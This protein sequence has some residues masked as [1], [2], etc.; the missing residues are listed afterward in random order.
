MRKFIIDTWESIGG[1]RG[2]WRVHSGHDQTELD[3]VGEG[4][5]N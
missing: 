4:E 2:I 3:C 1:R 5:G